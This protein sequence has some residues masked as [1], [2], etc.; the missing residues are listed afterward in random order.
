MSQMQHGQWNRGFLK[1]L[2]RLISEYWKSEEKKWAYLYLVGIV[3]LTVA[4]VYMTLLLNDWFNDFYSALQNYDADAVYH[5]LI[6]FTGFAFAYIAFSVY[7][8]YIQQLL[9]LRWRNWMTARYLTKWTEHQMYYRME[10]F[11]DG[12]DNPDQRISEDIKLFTQQTLS[13]MMGMLKAVT[14]IVC[15]IFVLWGLSAPISF[16]IAGTD[17]HIYG[18]LVWA[19]LLYSVLGTWVTHWV[20]HRLVSLNFVQQRLEAD[21]RFGM[22]RLRESAESVAFYDGAPS[23]KHLLF[24]R[25]QLVLS[26]TLLIIKKQKQLSWLTNSYGQIAIIFPFVVSVPRYLSKEISLGGLMQIGNCFGKVQESMSYFVDVYASLAE[27]QSCAERILTFDHH[28]KEIL[29]DTESHANALHRVE[30]T[31]NLSLQHVT[32]ALPDTRVLLDDACCTIH[33]GD[34]VLLK[35]PS[36]AGKSTLLR[37]LAG[38]WPYAAGTIEAPKESRMFIPQRPYMPM[39]TLR[40]AAAYP[41]KWAE[42]KDLL[43]LLDMCGLSHLKQSLDIEADWSHMLSLGEQ[44]RLAFVRIFLQRPKWVFLDEATSAMDEDMET[45]LYGLLSAMENITIISIGHRS[46]LDKWHTRMVY[47][48]KEKKALVEKREARGA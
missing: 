25:F 5:G 47:I 10:M 44:Q 48:D 20:G 42:D 35:G 28:M 14:T 26:N 17:W 15:F 37:V 36:G 2:F 4:A 18:Y 34:R 27:W 32:V 1:D 12:A 30:S 7:A 43:P 41:G 23:E 9:S 6:R 46:T 13:F 22:I 19:A 21:F 31:G 3:V 11:A 24:R 45:K 29:A 8:Y 16:T 33:P 40:E 38:F 39:G